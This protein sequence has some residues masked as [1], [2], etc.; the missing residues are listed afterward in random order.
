M[1]TPAAA[2]EQA[3][4]GILLEAGDQGAD[5]RL[6]AIQIARRLGNGARRHDFA[7]GGK[8]FQVHAGVSLET[9]RGLSR[10]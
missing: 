4:T 5:G 9:I 6:G 7:K 8:L 1:Q 10:I 2:L 3:A